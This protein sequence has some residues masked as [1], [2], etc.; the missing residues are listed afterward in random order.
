MSDQLNTVIVTSFWNRPSL[1]KGL[2]FSS[3]RSIR[4]SWRM[5]V[6]DNGSV[7]ENKDWLYSWAEEMANVKILR[8]ESYSDLAD[9]RMSSAEHGAALDLAMKELESSEEM[10]VIADSDIIF[11]KPRWDEFFAEKLKEYDHVTTHR[12]TCEDCPAPYISAFYMSFIK[13]NSLTFSPRVNDKME[14]I[15]PTNKNDVGWKMNDLPKDR[16]CILSQAQPGVGYSRAL[17][18]KYESE[19]IAEHLSAG[20]KRKDGRIKK[21]MSVCLSVLENNKKVLHDSEKIKNPKKKAK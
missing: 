8:R 15:R 21:W 7:A 11:M 18:I 19:Q 16:W 9:K 14:V 17:S 2:H 20:R 10:I 1:L 4:G 13:N 6:V 3:R 12:K 5:L